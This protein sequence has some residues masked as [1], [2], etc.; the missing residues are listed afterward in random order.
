MFAQLALHAFCLASLLRP[1]P[2][3]PALTV[4]VDPALPR[5]NCSATLH[6]L[7]QLLTA[8]SLQFH[9]ITGENI[10]RV[11]V[12]LPPGWSGCT[13]GLSP[14][15]RPA[16]ASPDILL[17]GQPGPTA[18][19]SRQFG[20][21]GVAGRGVSLPASL[22]HRNT[23][24]SQLLSSLLQHRYGV[25]STH[26]STED[27]TRFPETFSLTGQQVDNCAEYDWTEK[28]GYDST[29]PTP[30]NLLCEGRS[31]LAVVRETSPAS[32][33]QLY[34]APQLEFSI[35]E[36]TRYLLVLDR[37]EQSKHVWE[38]LYNALYR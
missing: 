38:H 3:L 18:V 10:V 23:T 7:Q 35:T 19:T 6:S 33:P 15:S 20:G 4:W 31:P 36:S 12:E 21:C 8:T 32:A 30:H 5:H 11:E 16:P 17:T 29:A 25:F 27:P 22:L 13:A 9:N 34:T 14:A 2:A 28:A 37:S 1:V 24:T 26:G